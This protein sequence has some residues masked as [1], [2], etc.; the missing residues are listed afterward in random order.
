MDSSEG[1]N[2]DGGGGSSAVTQRGNGQI[3]CITRDCKRQ[4]PALE[5]LLCLP[6]YHR[7]CQSACRVVARSRYRTSSMM[8]T[9]AR[10]DQTA[11]FDNESGTGCLNDR[12]IQGSPKESKGHAHPKNVASACPDRPILPSCALLRPPAPSCALLRPL[13]LSRDKKGSQRLV[14]G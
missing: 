2:D 14:P 3:D 11:R 13:L 1:C 10:A 6:C 4:C 12:I 8:R 5:A 9:A 7:P